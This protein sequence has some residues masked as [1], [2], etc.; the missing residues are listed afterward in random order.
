MKI[1]LGLGNPGEK[2]INTRHNIGFMALD[3]LLEKYEPLAKT[4][5]EVSNDPNAILKKQKKTFAHVKKI[6]LKDEDVL[7]AKPSTFMN[8][9]GY[10]ASHL[11]S[12]YKLRPEDIFVVY[13]DGDLPL[14]KMRIRF[15]G[16]AGGH[17]GVQNIIDV[18]GSD[19]FLRIR[20]G[21]GRPED[22]RHGKTKRAHL[23][24]YVLGKFEPK[25]KHSVKH[26]LKEAE[27]S[28]QLILEHGL[29][30]YMSKYNK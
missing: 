20:L 12:F 30:D 7:L 2:Y 1:I 22:E 16:G 4:V 17:R 23:D 11:L 27:K 19:K 28:I 25:E 18:T 14:G 13:D 15:G 8:N 5:W 24:K 9:S 26:L 6:K 29:E 21:I 10:A 3:F